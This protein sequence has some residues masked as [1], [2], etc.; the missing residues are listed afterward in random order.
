[1]AIFLAGE[2]LLIAAFFAGE[3]AGLAAAAAA[4]AAA[5]LVALAAGIFSCKVGSKIRWLAVV[6]YILNATVN[7]TETQP[8]RTVFRGF[9]RKKGW[10]RLYWRQTLPRERKHTSHFSAEPLGPPLKKH[11]WD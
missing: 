11:P 5:F 8:L 10:F 3:A 4:G 1:L 6:K 7:A 2:A 9:A